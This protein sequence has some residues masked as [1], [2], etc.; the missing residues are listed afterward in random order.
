MLVLTLAGLAL[1]PE[2]SLAVRRPGASRKPTIG[3][4]HPMRVTPSEPLTFDVRHDPSSG[5]VG[6]VLKRIVGSADDEVRPP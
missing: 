1:A 5:M 3:P 2:H 6:V 4:M